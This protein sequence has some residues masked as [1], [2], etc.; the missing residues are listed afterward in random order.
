[1]KL[2]NHCRHR[3][4]LALCGAAH[5]DIYPSKPIRLLVLFA[6]GGSSDIVSRFVCGRNA[7]D[8]RPL[9]W[10]KAK[11]GGAGNIAMQEAKNSA[12]DGWAPSSRPR[13]H[14]SRESGHVSQTAL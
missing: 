13:R 6:P 4:A 5:A 8:A 14:A 1:M 11:P 7:E 12:P 3:T 10:L 9:T 2:S